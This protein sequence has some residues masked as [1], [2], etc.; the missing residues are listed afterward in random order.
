MRRFFSK[1]RYP[2]YHKDSERK[3]EKQS[4]GRLCGRIN[5]ADALVNLEIVVNL[6]PVHDEASTVLFEREHVAVEIQMHL[7]IPVPGGVAEDMGNRLPVG[8][9]ELFAVGGDDVM[10]AL[11]E[12]Q[13]LVARVVQAAMVRYLDEIDL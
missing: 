12:V 8:M 4:R 10:V 2:S 7:L 1:T 13:Q 3:G 6:L 9:A 11:D 5:L